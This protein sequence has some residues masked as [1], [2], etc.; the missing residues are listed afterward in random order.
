MDTLLAK[1]IGDHGDHVCV[2]WTS[3]ENGK[4]MWLL[5]NLYFVMTRTRKDART[6]YNKIFVHDKFSEGM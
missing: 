4:P 2:K 1:S 3:N 6:K 5:L